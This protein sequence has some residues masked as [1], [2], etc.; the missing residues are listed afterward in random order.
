[1]LL[2]HSY[3][4]TKIYNFTKEDVLLATLNILQSGADEKN[5]LRI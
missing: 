5:V 1:M 2:I 4:F 3:T